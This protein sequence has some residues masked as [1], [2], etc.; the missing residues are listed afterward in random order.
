MTPKQLAELITKAIRKE[1]RAAMVS[2]RKTIKEEIRSAVRDEINSILEDASKTK[3]VQPEPEPASLSQLLSEEAIVVEGE[4]MFQGKGKIF[5]VL[6]QTAKENKGA[7]QLIPGGPQ[8]NEQKEFVFNTTN[9]PATTGNPVVDKTA[10]AQKMGYGNDGMPDAGAAPVPETV[11][12][13]VQVPTTNADGKPINLNKVNP[14]VIQS[15]MRNYGGFL[16]KMD[17]KAKNVRGGV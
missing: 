4:P 3:Q 13:A 12:P 14:N 8:I 5:D 9:T 2:T 10:L 17:E 1:I 16:K 7:G 15:M 6:N 11:A